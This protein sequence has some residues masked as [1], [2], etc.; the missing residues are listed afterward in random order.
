MQNTF[1][2]LLSQGDSTAVTIVLCAIIFGLVL[3]SVC[4]GLIAYLLGR[5]R[6]VMNERRVHVSFSKF[7]TDGVQPIGTIFAVHPAQ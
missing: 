6:R 4:C 7:T 2:M 3:L 1:S 5:H